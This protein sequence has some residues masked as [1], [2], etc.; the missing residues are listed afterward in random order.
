MGKPLLA[1]T[2]E[3]ARESGAFEKIVLSTEDQEIAETGRKYLAEVPFM[4][5]EELATDTASTVAVVRHALEWLSKNQQFK[6]DFV[7]VLEPTAPLRQPFHIRDSVNLLMKGGVDSI[8]SVSR[9]PHHFVPEKTLRIK[10]D[11]SLEGYDGTPIRKMIHRRQDLPAY[12][13]FN[14]LVFACR[15]DLIFE[16][17]PTLW[18]NKVFPLI[19]EEKY[20]VDL[21]IPEDWLVAECKMREILQ[22]RA[23]K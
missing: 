19:T 5:P 13:A 7:M 1:W 17:P 9:V 20:S 2:M 3:C 11:G 21:D 6:P 18:G 8:A 15:Y 14:G 23:I 10:A 16:N 4:R 12:Y 22:E